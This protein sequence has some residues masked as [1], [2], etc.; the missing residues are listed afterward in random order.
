M[1]EKEISP[2]T[3]VEGLGRVRLWLEGEK[4]S[5]V[6][7]EIF[8]SPRFFEAFLKGREI[9]Q[10][11]DIVARICGLCPIAYQMSAVEAFEKILKIEIPE[12]IKILR[13]V[14]YCG[15]WISS[16]SAH[17][18]FLHLPDFFGKESSIELAK[19]R[20]DLIEKG[21]TIRKA[22]NRIIEMLGGRHVHPVNMKVGGFYRLPHERHREE[23]LKLI[24][25]ALPVAEECL[26]EFISFNFPQFSRDYNFISLGGAET[27]PFTEGSVISSEG[28]SVE[29]EEFEERFE[30]FQEAHSTALYS[31]IKGKG[32]YM[33][34]SV[35]RFNNNFHLLDKDLQEKLKHIHP[36]KNP[37]MSIIARTAE[38]VYSLREAK[39]LLEKVDLQEKPSVDYELEEGEGVGIT[40]APRGILYHKYRINKKGTV[41]YANIIPPTAQNQGI[42][43]EDLLEG[44][45]KLEGKKEN[46]SER[47]VRNYDPCISCASHFLEV[48][49]ED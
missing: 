11:I 33:V 45:N 3:R 40:E 16:H 28:W 41:E 49:F 14:L 2:L 44:L 30:E 4:V 10:V 35:S 26:E 12:H 27:Y 42:M 19:E 17:V 31:R 25:S 29:K 22:G 1:K 38:I 21:L 24:E 6:R 46:L 8:E 13:R 32:F 47:L 15:E 43:E 23:V 39:R 9:N 48:V 20:K 18:F 37:F 7:L 36:L 34:G 5:K